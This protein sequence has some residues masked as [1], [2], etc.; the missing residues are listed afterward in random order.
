LLVS[1]HAEPDFLGWEVKHAVT[2]FARPDSGA[3]ITLMTP[4]PTGRSY[5]EQ[6]VEAFVR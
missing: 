2:S 4:E 3:A 6:G 5:K 1:L